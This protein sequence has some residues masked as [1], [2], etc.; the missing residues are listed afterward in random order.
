[1]TDAQMKLLYPL[2]AFYVRD[3]RPLP[4]VSGVAGEDVPEPYRQL[5]VHNG[6]M[7]PALEAFHGERIH[8][9][10]LS[11][12]LDGDTLAREV[13]LTL[14]DSVRPVE[15]GAIVI[16]LRRFPPAAR[17]EILESK[18][19]LGTILR[20]HAIQH[21]SRPQAFLCVTSD[22]LMKEA[23]QLD[24]PHA[25]YGRR[26]VLLDPDDHPL[27]DIVEILPPVTRGAT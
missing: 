6:D 3:G 18:T 22:D 8:L 12:R 7:T 27:A 15:F 10:L 1:V 14:D 20:V 23:L 26:N 13:V 9:R 5:L 21:R 11:R 4:P 25:L 2:D 24:G 19:P 16:H 17:E